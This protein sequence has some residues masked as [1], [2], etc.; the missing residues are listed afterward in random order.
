V[1]ESASEPAWPRGAEVQPQDLVITMLGTY[2]HHQDRTVWSGGLVSLLGEFGFSPGAARIALIR[3]A[4]RGLL[5]R[6]RTGRLAFY[7][8]TPRCR[9]LLEEGDRRIF[10]LGKGPNH[11]EHWTILWHAIPE[12]RRLERGRLARR[13]RFLGFGTLQD[14][15]WVSPHDR[16]SEVVQV[17][18]DLDV[19]EFSGVLIGAPAAS[20]D[21]RTF[22]S[23]VWPMGALSERYRLYVEQFGMFANGGGEKLTDREAFVV[24]TRAMH[25]FRN[26]PADDP[27]LPD[28]YIYQPQFRAEAIEVFSTLYERLAEASDRYFCA[29]TDYAATKRG[30][31]SA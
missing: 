16:E 28:D 3:L 30:A 12:E 20:L 25:A 21:F 7:R 13:L 24:R 29:A 17:I 2:V 31:A 1:L 18:E 15:T 9:K 19:S 27:E 22:V 26:F 14:G 6:I 10:L 11:A 5:E 23:R 4:N 8:L